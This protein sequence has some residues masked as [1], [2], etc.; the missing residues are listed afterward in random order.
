MLAQLL[1]VE[2][3]PHLG[4]LLRDYLSADYQVHHSPTIRD[5][6]GWLGTHSAQLILLDL[7]LPDGDGLDLV[8][9]LRQYSSTPVLIL[10]ARSA[11]QERVSGL[12]AGADDYLTKPFAMPELDARI[13]ALLRRTAAGGGVSLGNTSLSTS[14]LTLQAGEE[15]ATLTEHEARILEL[16]MRTPDRVFSRADIES[17]LYGWETPNSN[18]VEVRISQLRK[19]LEQV[20]SDLRI[21]TIRNVG[22]VLQS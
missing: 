2:D 8:S 21:R 15:N 20:G 4:P 18:S 10:S 11:V 14:S 17:H 1:L 16:M 5:A 12:N 3:D 9:A 7:N 19:K 13:S 22:Y 6:Q